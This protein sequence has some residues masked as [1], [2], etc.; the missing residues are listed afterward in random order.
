MSY[1]QEIVRVET[2]CDIFQHI[3]HKLN[4]KLDDLNG[5]VGSIAYL[6][7]KGPG[8]ESRQTDLVKV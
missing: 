3:M 6:I 8:F 2:L 7:P 1:D 4:M 5:S